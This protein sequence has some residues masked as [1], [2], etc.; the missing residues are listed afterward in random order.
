MQPPHA[1]SF[2]L[3]HATQAFQVLL[4]RHTISELLV[5]EKQGSPGVAA[6]GDLQVCARDLQVLLLLEKQGKNSEEEEE[7][8]SAAAV[9]EENHS[10]LESDQHFPLFRI[11]SGHD[12]QTAADKVEKVVLLFHSAGANEHQFDGLLAYL[13]ADEKTFVG[14]CNLPG[15][16]AAA[17]EDNSF[18]TLIPAVVSVITQTLASIGSLSEKKITFVGDSLG[19]LVAYAAL[20]EFL[21][22]ADAANMDTTMNVQLV[23]SGNSPPS[24][25]A[26]EWG[27]GEKATK[28]SKDTTDEELVKWLSEANARGRLCWLCD[29]IILQF[30]HQSDIFLSSFEQELLKGSAL[31]RGKNFCERR[32]LQLPEHDHDL[33]IVD[34]CTNYNIPRCGHPCLL[35]GPS[36]PR[37]GAL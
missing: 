17:E 18:H 30:V 19:S 33:I 15:R 7:N 9:Q 2:T 29:N 8:R 28:S 21:A 37:P 1:K 31:V 22:R 26:K 11:V 6:A 20:Q 27:L 10:A 4:M 34:A 13:D 23:V 25:A 14:I 5:L 24:V 32:L 3:L 35:A 12:S 16:A 36:A